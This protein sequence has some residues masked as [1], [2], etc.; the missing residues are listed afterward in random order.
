MVCRNTTTI[1]TKSVENTISK[2]DSHSRKGSTSKAKLVKIDRLAI[3]RIKLAK[4]N[5]PK[6]VIYTIQASR[7]PSTTRIY[8][9]TW[10]TFVKWCIEHHIDPTSA[11]EIE[12][13]LFLQA[14]LERGLAPSTLKRQ[15]AALATVLEGRN[16]KSLSQDKRIKSFL[17]GATNLRPPKIHRY[18]SW[19]INLV[20]QALTKSPFEPVA[21]ISIRWLTIKLAFLIAITS[22][23]RVSE[24]AALSIRNDLCTFYPDRVV[25]RL[26]TTFIP[27]INSYFHRAQEIVL[28][29]FCP[30]PKHTLEKMWHTLDVRRTLISYMKRTA[31]FRKT[32]ALFVSFLPSSM[33]KKVSSNT[34]GR[35][36]KA[37]ISAAYAS[38]GVKVPSRV[39]PHSTRSVATS[40]AWATQASIEEICKAATWSSISS[41]VKHYKIDSFASADA[42][43]GRRVLQS[44]ISPRQ[45][46]KDLETHPI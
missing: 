7:R 45:Q 39:L 22:A 17:R 11:N 32:E 4:D 30:D 9:A 40:A 14:G 41:F 29:N 42:A 24:I 28:P 46:E 35:W 13:L 8:N 20:L 34:V 21:S 31:T 6:E 25:L 23:R 37:C 15:V 5:L 38:Q 19:D 33:G 10:N 26:D 2:D 3:E 43:F 36:I 16:K 27:K 12:V 44:I 18:P 1:D